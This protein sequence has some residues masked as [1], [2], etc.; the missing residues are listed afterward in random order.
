MRKGM[1]LLALFITLS[2]TQ[3]IS[4]AAVVAPVSAPSKPVSGEP[5]P[6]TVQSA[7]KEFMGLSR[8]EKKTRFKAV[9]KEIR[10]FNAARKRGEDISTNTILLAILAIL[11]PPLAVYLH[12]GEFNTKFWISLVL[13]LLAFITFF[14]WIIPVVFALLVVLNLI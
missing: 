12:Q 13:C 14:L 4:Y 9:K 6:A 11:L 2:S 8:K 7:M 5:D 1:L 3:V 10:E